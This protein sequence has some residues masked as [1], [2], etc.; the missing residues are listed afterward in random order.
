MRG[1]MQGRASAAVTFYRKHG[2]PPDV[3]AKAVVATLRRPRTVVATPR[4]QVTPIWLLKRFVPRAAGVYSRY[5]TR[6][7]G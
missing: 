1:A 6:A 7:I 2:S 3:V 5:A 4:W